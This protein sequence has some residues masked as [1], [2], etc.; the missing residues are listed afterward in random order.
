M[1]SGGTKLK[2]PPPLIFCQSLGKSG[3]W[4][5]VDPVTRLPNVDLAE[6]I[7]PKMLPI[8]LAAMSAG[9]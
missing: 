2:I 5:R 3:G 9:R 7:R 8:S 4:I 6:I 1:E